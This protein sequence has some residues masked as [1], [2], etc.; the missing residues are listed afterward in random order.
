MNIC[1]DPD[2]YRSGLLDLQKAIRGKRIRI[3]NDPA[4]LLKLTRD[5]IS[6]SLAG[7]DNLVS[8]KCVRFEPKRPQ[9]FQETF[10]R[11][12]FEYPVLVR[13][14]SSQTGKGLIKVDC[15]ED[16]LKI[17]SVAWFGRPLYMTQFIDYA[18]K[19]HFTKVRVVS[20]DGRFL[21]HSVKQSRRWQ[22]NHNTGEIPPDEFA[23]SEQSISDDLMRDSGFRS[24][25]TR[26]DTQIGLN[27]WGCDLGLRGDGMVVFFEANPAMTVTHDPAYYKTEISKGRYARLHGPIKEELQSSLLA[28]TGG[29]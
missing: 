25:L 10:G 23:A 26:L 12:G 3:Y 13:P 19:G 9:D 14:G 17:F 22:I 21:V 28:F 27:F 20:V 24:L 6:R 7:I 5:Q 16:W 15:P 18:E 29:K 8:P 11:E 1:A 2:E 4:A